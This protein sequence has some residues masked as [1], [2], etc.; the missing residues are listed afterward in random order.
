LRRTHIVDSW[1]TPK[2]RYAATPI[3]FFDQ[4]NPH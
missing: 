1:R 4:E 2:R 3:R